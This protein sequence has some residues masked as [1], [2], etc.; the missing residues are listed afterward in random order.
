MTG[1]HRFLGPP[2]SPDRRKN[3]AGRKDFDSR[4]CRIEGIRFASQR[5]RRR[6]QNFVAASCLFA[7]ENLSSSGKNGQSAITG[8]DSRAEPLVSL[9]R[10]KSNSCILWKINQRTTSFAKNRF[11]G[12]KIAVL[13][14]GNF[15][16]AISTKISV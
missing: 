14:G 3:Q 12:G 7:S 13:H 9:Y 1:G 4:T 2:I 5:N 11:V 8:M 10:I 15:V 6:K 16:E